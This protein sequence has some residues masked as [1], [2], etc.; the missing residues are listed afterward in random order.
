MQGEMHRFGFERIIMFGRVFA[1]FFVLAVCLPFA[2]SN[3][4]HL[5]HSLHITP[6]AIDRVLSSTDN[7]T[8]YGD[9]QV[10][11]WSLSR[12]NSSSS[13]LLLL[14]NR[15]DHVSKAV[16]SFCFVYAGYGTTSSEEFGS[17]CV[18]LSQRNLAMEDIRL[19]RLIVDEKYKNIVEIVPY[20]EQISFRFVNV[21]ELGNFFS[22]SNQGLGI[23]VDYL[24]RLKLTFK[25]RM[26]ILERYTFEDTS[27][28]ESFILSRSCDWDDF[29]RTPVRKMGVV[30]LPSPVLTNIEIDSPCL[31]LDDLSVP[32][33]TVVKTTSL[34]FANMCDMFVEKRAS[35]GSER[36]VSKSNFEN[37]FWFIA[38]G[39][40]LDFGSREDR[41][42]CSNL[43]ETFMSFD[44]KDPYSVELG[45]HNDMP[46]HMKRVSSPWLYGYPSRI[47]SMVQRE[48]FVTDEL[49]KQ[50]E[51]PFASSE[52]Q[53]P[54]AVLKFLNSVWSTTLSVQP[55]AKDVLIFLEVSENQPH[56]TFTLDLS[57]FKANYV[58]VDCRALP[59]P[60][61]LRVNMTAVLN[62]TLKGCPLYSSSWETFTPKKM[63]Q[64]ILDSVHSIPSDIWALIFPCAGNRE[65]LDIYTCCEAFLE[66]K[67]LVLRNIPLFPFKIL[68]R[69]QFCALRFLKTLTLESLGITSSEGGAFK[70][71]FNLTSLSLS[72]N[73]LTY[74]P[75]GFVPKVHHLDLMDVSHNNISVVEK[76]FCH[77]QFIFVLDLSFNHI[78]EPPDLLEWTSECFVLSSYNLSHNA[79]TRLQ[80]FSSDVDRLVTFNDTYWKELPS[81]TRNYRPLF[82]LDASWNK[83]S[84]VSFH[85]PKFQHYLKSENS[86]SASEFHLDLSHNEITSMSLSNLRHLSVLNLSSNGLETGNGTAE[87]IVSNC[88]NQ[89][90]CHIDLSNNSLSGDE[91]SSWFPSTPVRS[92]DLSNNS[93]TSFPYGITN[94][95]FSVAL[96]SELASQAR[97]RV[98][99]AYSNSFYYMSFIFKG[100]KIKSI[101]K[102]ICV[103][104][105]GGNEAIRVFYDFSDCGVEYLSDEALQC[106]V[107]NRFIINLNSN[108][109]SC[110]PW[111]S[112][113]V[114]AL[115]VMNTNIRTFNSDYRTLRPRKNSS[116]SASSILTYPK[117]LQVGCLA[118]SL[119]SK[120]LPLCCSLDVYRR[121]FRTTLPFS[122]W[123]YAE[124]DILYRLYTQ[125]GTVDFAT[126]TLCR[127]YGREMLLSEFFYSTK[128]STCPPMAKTALNCPSP[129]NSPSCK[130]TRFSQNCFVVYN[131]L[132]LC[133]TAF[134]A[135]YIMAT[136]LCISTVMPLDPSALVSKNC[137]SVG[138]C[139]EP[140]GRV[141]CYTY[142]WGKDDIKCNAE[143]NV[144]E[145]PEELSEE[146]CMRTLC[147]NTKIKELQK[148]YLV[149]DEVKSCYTVPQD[150]ICEENYLSILPLT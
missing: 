39:F 119:S 96:T 145:D 73:L 141:S 45:Y 139:K 147:G 59:S 55:Q 61:A 134:L 12:E 97:D 117:S 43:T 79:L 138:Y 144:Y 107:D 133:T 110:F 115:S 77:H 108:P 21:P 83:I 52:D 85:M 120:C 32:N 57:G 34:S 9:N 88:C 82:T 60:P 146:P 106:K 132:L 46:V 26:P 16:N 124:D 54:K 75:N 48:I 125:Q 114:L 109:I 20:M 76:G 81:I 58:N 68:Q 38:Q 112:V 69:H 100:N 30:S 94:L 84:N 89:Y 33:S 91:I 123:T 65:E 5:C 103:S 41:Q 62:L 3:N 35:Y 64:I 42:K 101:D 98:Y 105:N 149:L 93:F 11:L 27:R 70:N 131:T 36:L 86:S 137:H 50:L 24:R 95:P 74:L 6:Q 104:N 127:H 17:S 129:N 8:H 136:A 29:H 67:T 25:G 13:R 143:A 66:L 87:G 72:H 148:T 56:D 99:F 1:Y 113:N 7:Y 44:N 63:H 90:G 40:R 14:L 92:L 130:N 22:N 4:P 118:N 150:N 28:L 102:S 78:V 111:E 37:T 116:R 18:L 49:I 122:S 140:M 71:L 2:T 121:N 126:I 15:T 31:L 53:M 51:T 135:A 128:S 19:V 142:V 47:Y 80:C 23:G 10:C